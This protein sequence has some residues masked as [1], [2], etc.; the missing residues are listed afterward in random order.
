MTAS[1]D[2]MIAKPR[3]YYEL[4]AA[5]GGTVVFPILAVRY[6]V[7]SLSFIFFLC[8]AL[9]SVAFGLHAL[10]MRLRFG[11][12]VIGITVGP[13]IRSVELTQLVRVDYHRSGNAK[14]YILRD[15]N[16]GKL[17]VELARFRRESEWKPLILAAADR[18]NAKVDPRARRSLQR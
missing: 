7:T 2:V 11:N 4:P 13:W 17:T 1:H 16:G 18:C 3:V 6:P 15:S 14:A 9:G 8:L 12:D 5:V 10:L